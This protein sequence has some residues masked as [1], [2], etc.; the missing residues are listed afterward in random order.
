MGQN[1]AMI[2]EEMAF[3]LIT[4]PIPPAVALLHHRICSLPLRASL[5]V[6]IPP[7]LPHIASFPDTSSTTEP[8]TAMELQ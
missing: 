7:R 1:E 5:V 6:F 4:P 3:L 2:G 8:P